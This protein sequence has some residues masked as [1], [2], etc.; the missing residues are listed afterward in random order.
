M[1]SLPYS[2]VPFHQPQSAKLLTRAVEYVRWEQGVGLVRVFSEVGD[3]Q[4]MAEAR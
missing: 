3:L 4:Q 2:E 1:Y